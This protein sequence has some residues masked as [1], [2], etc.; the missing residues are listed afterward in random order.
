MIHFPMFVNLNNQPVLVIGGGMVALR[1]IEKLRPYGPHITVISPKIHPDIMRIPGLYL[2]KRPFEKNDL[3]DTLAMV[4]AS[5]NDSQ[6]N[7]R[8]AA[9]CR[10]K[11]IPVNVVDDPQKCSFL[12]PALIQKGYLSA[13]ISTGGSSPTAAI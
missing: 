2:Q 13:G 1:K 12:F 3:N 9:I 5:S 4:I 6:L 10:E 11:K 7:Q 8:I